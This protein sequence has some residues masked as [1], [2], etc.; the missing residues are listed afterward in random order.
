MEHLG[1]LFTL[2]S[3]DS[4]DSLSVHGDG[5]FISKPKNVPEVIAA[6]TG[7]FWSQT[8]QLSSEIVDGY[9]N[10]FQNLLDELSEADEPISTK[11]AMHHFIFTLGPEF[12]TIQNNFC[13]GNLPPEWHAQDWP[14][15]LVLC[16]D[17]YH[18]VTPFM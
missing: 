9:Y 4:Y 5:N 6:K 12:S 7:A 10:C 11:S 8:K 1:S 17:F 16:H 2:R 3:S 13:I 15:L 14:T 18:S